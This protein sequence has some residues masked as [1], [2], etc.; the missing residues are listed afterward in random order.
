MLARNVL[1]VIAV[2]PSIAWAEAITGSVDFTGTA[3]V[4][5]KLDRS[6]EAFCAK[7]PAVDEAV[8]VKNRKL[9][10]V[11]VHVVKG[12][13]DAAA[14]EGA[15]EVVID[16]VGCTYRP[17]VATAVVGQK[18]VAK[19]TDPILHNVHTFLG[20]ATLFNKGMPDASA[21]PITHVAS[22]DGV[23]RWRCDVHPWMRAYIGV[24]RN[25]FQAVTGDDGAFKIDNVPPGTYTLEAWHETYGTKTIE[26]TVA[27]GKGASATFS[28][29]G[30]E[31]ATM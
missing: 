17:R 9:V 1:A 22:K 16:Q 20:K 7:T 6:Q 19:N 11:W 5:Q 30:T 12:A 4:M 13:P 21:K 29:D 3:P 14:A 31:K 27:A 24:N 18:V 26:V 2:L 25:A 10:N 28:F 23:I 8:I 15:P